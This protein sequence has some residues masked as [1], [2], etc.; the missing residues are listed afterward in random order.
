[1]LGG[2]FSSVDIYLPSYKLCIMVDGEHHFK[3]QRKDASKFILA[4]RKQQETDI[5]FNHHALSKGFS[6]L[7][8]HYLD[9]GIFQE[10]IFQVVL[11]HKNGKSNKIDFSKSFDQDSRKPYGLHLLVPLAQS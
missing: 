8:L 1:M 10:I 7:R 11:A 2:N 3:R 9:S 4:S 6:V 5:K